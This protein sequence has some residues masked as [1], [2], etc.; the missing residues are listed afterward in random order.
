MSAKVYLV[1]AGPGDAELI[2]L[3]GVRCLVAADTIIYDCLVNPALLAHARDDAKLIYVGK[4]GYSEHVT[5][6]EINALLVEEALRD[7]AGAA[8]GADAGDDRSHGGAG[9]SGT[10]SAPVRN[11][12]PATRRVI[13]RLKGGDPFVFGRGGEEA[14]VLREH[15]IDFEVIPGVT[16]GIAAPACAG[17]PVT[18]RGVSSSVAFV[19]G[20]EDPSKEETSLNWEGIAHGTQTLCFY[21]GMRNLPLIARRL[22]E[23]GRSPEEPVALIRWGATPQQEVLTGTLADIAER[24][25]TTGFHAPAIIVVGDVVSL[26]EELAWHEGTGE[27][28]HA[29]KDATEAAMPPSPPLAGL[30]IAVTRAQAQAGTL[31]K[32]LRT[33][34]AN[35]IACPTIR[36]TPVADT[37]EIDRAAAL[38]TRGTYQWIVFTSANGVEH[39]FVHLDRLRLDARAFGTAKIAAIG[40]S[41]AEALKRHG[42]L[43]DVVPPEYRAESIATSLLGAGVGSGTRVLIPRARRARDILPQSLEAAGAQVDVVAVYETERANSAATRRAIEA[44]TRGKIRALTF[45]S[46]STVMEFAALL[47]DYLESK[48][49]TNED[50]E[51]P[52]D[53]FAHIVRGLECYSIG[54]VTSAALESIGAH[55]QAQA[56]TYTVDGLVQAIVNDFSC[57]TASPMRRGVAGVPRAG[58]AATET[59]QWAVSPSEPLLEHGT[60]ASSL[61]I[62]SCATDRIL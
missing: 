23:A 49:E 57:E 7:N 1:G 13:V 36:I 41:T 4:R 34:G 60:P 37:S 46:T 12:A 39:F 47:R 52:R 42:I 24:A 3:K 2:T 32:Q 55:V 21:M 20:N 22:M 53:A 59:A 45:T 58:C 10:P 8:G 54:P 17:I 5:Q 27:T 19:T 30:S 9:E 56:Q 48:A 15:G 44:V 35:V 33:L 43:V 18:H 29:A 25:Q 51:N 26:R 6:D 38:L 61:R 16:S 50:P 11:A 40:A 14:L 28:E 62:G 31:V